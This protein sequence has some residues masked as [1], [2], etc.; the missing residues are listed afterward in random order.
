MQEY[1]FPAEAL[2][3]VNPIPS[4]Y[5]VSKHLG[6]SVT[7]LYKYKFRIFKG[8]LAFNSGVPDSYSLL[9]DSGGGFVL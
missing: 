6:W 2:L 8:T 4:I 3:D 5:S 7:T 9:G 1:F